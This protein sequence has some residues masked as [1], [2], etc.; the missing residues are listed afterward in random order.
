MEELI[1]KL[2]KEIAAHNRL[3]ALL[4]SRHNVDTF[5]KSDEEVIEEMKEVSH[6]VLEWCYEYPNNP[7]PLKRDNRQKWGI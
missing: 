6:S 4:I 1:E 3:T 7:Y 2:V 5:D